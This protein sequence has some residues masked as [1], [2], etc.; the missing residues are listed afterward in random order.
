MIKQLLAF[1]GFSCII[2]ANHN[3]NGQILQPVKWEFS[4]EKTAPNEYML[5]MKASIDEGWKVYSKDIPEAEIRPIPTSVTFDNLPAQVELINGIQEL[6]RAEEKEEPLFDNLVIKWYKKKLT[7]RQQVKI[8]KDAVIKGYVT[9]MTCDDKQ[10]LPP[11]DV[12]FFFDLKVEGSSSASD[13][14]STGLLEPVKWNI[15]SEKINDTEYYVL[16]KATIDE[17]W[18][19][20]SQHLAAG[21]PIPTSFNFQKYSSIELIGKVEELGNLQQQKEPLF[22]NMMV[23]YFKHDAV[24]RQKIKLNA[25]SAIVKGS[26]EFQTCDDSKCLPPETIEFAVDVISGV[27]KEDTVT[28][29]VDL[30]VGDVSKEFSIDAQPYQD[31]GNAAEEKS[32]SLFVN[33]IKGFLGG[34]I[35]LLMPCTFPMIPLTIS[36]FTKRSTT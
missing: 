9:F 7:L 23:K 28:G 33:F 26:F 22:N 5:I 3:L 8:S 24:F 20:Y 14:Q 27:V 16:F 10:C 6:G 18:K 31:C 4:A 29:A 32:D 36:F 21:G 17:G 30:N 2:N 13:N 15:T 25:D 12:E 19:L 11:E 1:I 35:A 34:L